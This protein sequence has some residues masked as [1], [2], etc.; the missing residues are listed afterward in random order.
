[1]ARSATPILDL[2][3]APPSGQKSLSWKGSLV[4]IPAAIL[5]AVLM[6][7]MAVFLLMNYGIPAWFDQLATMLSARIDALF[8]Y[9]SLLGIVWILVIQA[10]ATL[11]HEAGHALAAAFVGWQ[12]VEFRVAPFSLVRQEGRWKVRL[13]YKDFPPGLVRADPP[14]CSR[15]HHKFRLYALGGPA[16]NLATAAVA[17]VC[18]QLIPALSSFLIIFVLVSVLQGLGN[19]LPIRVRNFELASSCSRRNVEADDSA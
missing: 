17:M 19:L 11:C 13:S 6:F 3:V 5:A 10:L 4:A 14:N 2:E 12:I 18:A 1:M 8:Q 9:G 15:F 16:A 7:A